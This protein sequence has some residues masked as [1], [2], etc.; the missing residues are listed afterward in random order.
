MFVLTTAD[1]SSQP[2]YATFEALTS[3]HSSKH[4]P[5]TGGT[6]SSTQ[7]AAHQLAQAQDN[8][9]TYRN[10]LLV[11]L[12][13]V[14]SVEREVVQAA[15][16]SWLLEETSQCDRVEVIIGQNA[17]GTGTASSDDVAASRDVDDLRRWHNDYCGSCRADLAQLGKGGSGDN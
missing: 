13:I 1:G 12:R 7:R 16:E 4:S 14:D 8:I 6:P 15:W 2:S 11:A 9:G 5:W 17:T 3:P 10:G